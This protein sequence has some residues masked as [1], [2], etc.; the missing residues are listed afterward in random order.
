MMM[1]GFLARIS[2]TNLTRFALLVGRQAEVRTSVGADR[3]IDMKPG[4]ED[5]HFDQPIHP[6][7]A[8]QIKIGPTEA[9]ANTGEQLVLEAVLQPFHGF[10]E[11]VG[12]PTALVADDL[13]ALDADQRRDIADPP[14]LFGDFVGDE[15]TIGENLEEAIGMVIENLEQFAV[16]KRLAA[17][18][19][20]HAIAHGLGFVDQP[21]HRVDFDLCVAERPRRSS[22]LGSAN[23][24]C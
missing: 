24:S 2:T 7:L 1:I 21:I 6:A 3:A 13:V 17:E 22:I 9:G 5:A 16:H 12:S 14:Q 23:C 18:N 20:K 15:V 4:V 8:E 11:D 19:A 10:R